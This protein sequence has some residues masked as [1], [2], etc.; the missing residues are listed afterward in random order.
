MSHSAYMV[1]GLG[2][3]DEGKGSVVDYLVR[4]HRASLVVRF[5]GGA[6]AA[7]RVV[8]PDGK[9]HIFRQFGSG[10]LVPGVQTFLSRF[11]L[12]NPIEAFWESRLLGDA[13][14]RSVV[15]GDA[16]VTTPYHVAANRL[17]ELSRGGRRHGSCGLGIG[18]TVEDSLAECPFRLTVRDLLSAKEI[19]AKLK[20]H[21]HVKQIQLAGCIKMVGDTDCEPIRDAMR[22]LHSDDELS[23]AAEVFAHVGERIRVV[24]AGFLGEHLRA[25]GSTVFEGAQGVLLDQDFGTAPYNTWSKTTFQNALSLLDDT[26]FG[27]YREAVGVTR[28]YMTRHGDGPFATE[29]DGMT[30]SLPEYANMD[31]PWQGRF[32]CGRLDLPL[33]E[34]AV[35]YCKPDSIAVTCMDRL[36]E[37]PGA[38]FDLAS[39][40]ARLNI[41]I[42][43]LSYGPT[44]EGKVERAAESV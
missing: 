8:A 41:P 39:L 10:S 31:S 19:M 1:I 16:L 24:D 35:N 25:D 14:D 15:D 7:H 22:Q 6:Q 27:G 21:R 3:G 17:K 32:R 36:I 28:W 40:E 29:N 20:H 5:N 11:M 23:A 2:Y 38:K 34:S 26:G 42:R 18:E 37:V 4:H 43:L 33:L 12:F 44:A 30:R 9:C 13:L